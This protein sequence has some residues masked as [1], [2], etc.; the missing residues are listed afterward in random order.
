MNTPIAYED[1]TV[2]CADG[3]PLAARV[4]RPEPA[5]DRKRTVVITAATGAKASYYW[6]YA[7]FLAEQGF[8]AL[9]ADY[10]GVGR[11]APGRGAVDLRRLTARWHE[12][13][14]LDADALIGFALAEGAGREIVAVGHSFGGLALCLAPQ[15]GT[16]TR[17]LTVGAQH[18]HWPDYARGER[19]LMVWRWHLVMPAVSALCGYFPGRRL[20]W[21]EDVPR[22]VALDWA[23]GR[24]DFA[25]TIGQ[26]GEE[27]MARVAELEP[28]VLAVAAGD[29][30]F[31]T[32]AATAR[33]LGY[34]PRARA[35]QRRV[36]PAAVG[37]TKIGHLGLFHDRFRETLWPA[38][39]AWLGGG[40][41]AACR[42]TVE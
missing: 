30:P 23:R 29:D 4:F 38:S 18:A 13:G 31:A 27:I 11:S 17:L 36:D 1:V 40:G 3:Y 14:T 10:R 42:P 20:G 33:L 19:A 24:K 5:N 6:R 8:R 28:D 35:E 26:G 22:G 15:A 2:V 12:W 16:I 34:L 21:M 25:R 7:G 41:T 32:D 39:A 9:V 37:V